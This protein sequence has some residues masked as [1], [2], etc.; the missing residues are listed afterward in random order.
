M[1][2]WVLLMFSIMISGE[3]GLWPFQ[4]LTRH[5]SLEYHDS[6]WCLDDSS[7]FK[8][9]VYC[10]SWPFRSDH[11]YLI[12]CLIICQY[13]TLLCFHAVEN[14]LVHFCMSRAILLVHC[15]RTE[16][17]VARLHS[18]LVRSYTKFGMQWMAKQYNKYL[19][20]V[21]EYLYKNSP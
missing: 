15:K 4:S 8:K 14:L 13:L 21:I 2:C 12:C 10:C 20:A 19:L 5:L 1:Q 7:S 9:T 17:Y 18:K 11:Q 16:P 6:Y 3:H